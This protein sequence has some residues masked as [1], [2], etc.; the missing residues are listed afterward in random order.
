MA[1]YDLTPPNGNEAL[2]RNGYALLTDLEDPEYG[3]IV[4]SLERFQAEFL[5]RTR[6]IW[7]DGFPI[8]PDALGH[9]TR[10]WEYP[11]AW[12]TW[13][14]WAGGSSTP[15]PGSRSS[16]S[17]SRRAGSTSSAAMWTRRRSDTRRGSSART[18]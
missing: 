5:A 9:F 14:R 3:R 10:Q 7:D 17:P 15:A 4:Q 1:L 18:H 13:L 11:Y 12:G 8:P 6:T 16:R 2:A